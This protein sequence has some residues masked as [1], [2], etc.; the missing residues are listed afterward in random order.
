MKEDQDDAN[1]ASEPSLSP[2][3]SSP[4]STESSVAA[5]T[6]PMPSEH[7]PESLE[8]AGAD[9][10]LGCLLIVVIALSMLGLWRI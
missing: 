4:E 2:S 5:E 6:V 9:S 10:G 1:S 8:E 3:G 7:L